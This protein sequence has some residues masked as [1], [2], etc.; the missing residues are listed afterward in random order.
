MHTPELF[1]D[2]LVIILASLPVAYLCLRLKLPLLVGLMLTGIAIGP[3]G[4][5]FIH[6][7]EGIEILA[8]IGV[9]LLL[10]TIGLEFSIRKLREMKTLVLI[11]GG[12]QVGITIFVTSLIAASLGREVT[13]AIFFGFLIA[14]SSTAIVLKSYVDRQEVDSPHGRAAIGILLFQDICI[15]LMLLLIPILG[16]KDVVS[17]TSILLDLGASLGSLIVIVLLAWLLIPAFLKQVVR[18]RSTEVF[19]LTIVLL[20]LGLSWITF[21]FGLSLALGAFIAG[22]VLADTDFSHQA[23]AEI[24]PFRDVFNSLFFVSMGMLLSIEAFVQNIGSVA[25]LV[26]GLMI[27]K[28]LIIWGIVKLLGNP[29]RVA[30]TAAVGLAQIGEFSFVLAK[31]GRGHGLMPDTD[32]QVFLAASIIT[33]IATPFLITYAPAIGALVQGLL[34]DGRFRGLE[35]TEDDEA[36]VTS[37][38]GLSDHVIIVGYGLNGRNLSRVLRAVGVNYTVLELNP[39]VVKEAKRQG[40]KINFG[41]A[42]RREVLKH[43]EIERASA[44]VL[45]MSDPRSAR[46]TVKLARRINADI[47]IIVRTRYVTEITELYELGANEVIPEEFETSIEI[48]ARVLHRFGFSRKIIEGQIERIRKQGYEMLRTPSAPTTRTVELDLEMKS[49]ST[50]SVQIRKG[51]PAI[52]RTLGE[53]DLRGRTGATVVAV[54]HEG[55]TKINPGAKC[56]LFEGD[57][58]I[59]LGNG[60]EIAKAIDV[61]DP[62]EEFAMDTLRG[63]NP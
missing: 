52:G 33:M 8:E 53:I 51:S 39:E 17:L 57:I 34:R 7:L 32:Y 43:A 1:R 6:E 14:L 31:A 9:M 42:T 60:E 56:E 49:E 21:Q 28:A 25:L 63:F 41:D 15:V 5:G 19:L 12:L 20:C 22:V 35:N 36:H 47:H 13:Q 26:G 4:L 38:G 3:Y 24:L 55:D 10:F 40:E 29:Q 11:G 50:E 27:G 61:L 46:L 62:L 44:L 58:V 30:V 54:V 2:F 16:G 59:L 45:A 23:T 48:F 37:S 18:M